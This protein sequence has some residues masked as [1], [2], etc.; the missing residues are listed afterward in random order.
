MKP[1]RRHRVTETNCRKW[2][3]A[4]FRRQGQLASMRSS[5]LTFQQEVL[6][7]EE[8]W[9]DVHVEYDLVYNL[10]MAQ[11][12]IDIVDSALGRAENPHPTL[13]T[14]RQLNKLNGRRKK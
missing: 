6:K 9:K 3:L 2:H 7:K 11:K 4:R 13:K 10:K 1:R 12:H 5:L 14:I 8:P